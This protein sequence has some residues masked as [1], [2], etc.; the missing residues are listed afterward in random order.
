MAPKIAG[1]TTLCCLSRTAYQAHHLLYNFI[2]I[3][4][5]FSFFPI[6][7][8]EYDCRT[9]L[10]S[11]GVNLCRIIAS[12][13]LSCGSAT[14]YAPPPGAQSRTYVYLCRPSHD[15]ISNCG[16]ARLDVSPVLQIIQCVAVCY[17]G[18]AFQVDIHTWCATFAWTNHSR[19]SLQHL[20][21]V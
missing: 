16:R 3:V 2:W 15:A 19:C 17:R 14:E 4:L 1:E 6:V 13:A 20:L 18:L 7:D 10:S 8:D 5:G 12:M 21:L 9:P 11:S